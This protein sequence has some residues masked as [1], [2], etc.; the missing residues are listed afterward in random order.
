MLLWV[1]TNYCRKMKSFNPYDLGKTTDS[2]RVVKLN[3]LIKQARDKFK[4]EFIKSSLNISGMDI[5]L[6]TS[7]TRYGGSRLWFV[8]PVCLK[9]KGTM[10]Q[11]NILACRTCLGLKYRKQRY[12]GMIE[13]SNYNI[14]I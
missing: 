7:K 8:C 10:Y 9:R 3:E 6:T 13:N 4:L 11:D 12:K 1:T 14:N 2:L 5:E